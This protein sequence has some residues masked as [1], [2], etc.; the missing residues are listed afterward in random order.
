MERRRREGEEGRGEMEDRGVGWRGGGG[1]ERRGEMEGRER[2]ENGG[3]RGRVEGW[4]TRY[5]DRDN[6]YP[7]YNTHPLE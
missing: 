5:V 2:G 6:M 1:E 3:E 7:P 4:K